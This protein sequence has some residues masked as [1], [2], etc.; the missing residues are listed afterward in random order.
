MKVKRLIS[1]IADTVAPDFSNLTIQDDETNEYITQDVYNDY[2]HYAN[3]IVVSY[4]TYF[5]KLQHQTYYM[6]IR[7]PKH[8]YL[9]ASGSIERYCFRENIAAVLD[10]LYGAYGKDISVT[11]TRTNETV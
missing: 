5:D 4:K 8:L 2:Q 11:I 7:E 9:V 3:Y 1:V 6:R 10:E